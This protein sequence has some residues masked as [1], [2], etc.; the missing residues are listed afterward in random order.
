[1]PQ[2]A[3][4]SRQS[5]GVEIRVERVE[6]RFGG[7]EE[8]TSNPFHFTNEETETGKFKLLFV[9]QSIYFFFSFF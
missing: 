9:V 7:T 5:P 6:S 3:D 8:K 2:P 1:M 4:D